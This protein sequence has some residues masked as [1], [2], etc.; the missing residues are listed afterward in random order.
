MAAVS[1]LDFWEVE[2]LTIHTDCS[3]KLHVC[4]K[5][6][7]GQLNGYGAIANFIF[8]IWRPSAILQFLKYANFN[9]PHFFSA[10]TCMFTQNFVVIGEMIAEIM[11][12]FYLKYGDRPPSGIS[13]ENM[14]ILTFRTLCNQN[15]HAHASSRLVEWLRRYCEFS[16]FH[17][18]AFRHLGFLK[19]ANF[20][21]PHSFQPN[22]HVYV[23][24]RRDRMNDFG[25]IASFLFSIWRSVQPF[26]VVGVEF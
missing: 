7:R 3:H 17:M 10:P 26:C 11:R 15:L 2:I 23:K 13:G 5:F 16:I 8:P 6:R 12:V 9:L 14:Q 19:Y 25:D 18:A 22:L 21:L 20:N 1:H 4:A 24:F